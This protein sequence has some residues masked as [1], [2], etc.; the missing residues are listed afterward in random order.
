MA[1][2]IFSCV[3]CCSP[4]FRLGLLDFSLRMSFFLFLSFLFLSF[5]LIILISIIIN[6]IINI[7]NIIINIIID[8][9][10][11]INIILTT[12]YPIYITNPYVFVPLGDDGSRQSPSYAESFIRLL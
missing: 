11:I 12:T 3:N 7:I 5:Y 8:I 2:L 9:S 6:I 1:V 10:I 4:P